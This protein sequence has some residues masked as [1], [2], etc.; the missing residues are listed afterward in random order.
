MTDSV[1][2]PEPRGDG[3]GR[4]RGR[5]A[6][7]G[8]LGKLALFYRQVIAELRKVVW[9][10]RRQLTTYT[11]AVIVFVLIVIGI[12]TVLDWG[13]SRVVEYVFG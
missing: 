4:G 8:P 6:K 1:E 3:A 10:S 13:F 12:L 2:T 9:P 7:R 11:S 5:R